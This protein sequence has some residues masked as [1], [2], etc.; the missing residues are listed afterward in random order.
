MEVTPEMQ[1]LIVR[2][3]HGLPLGARRRQFIAETVDCLR[4]SKR[5]AQHLFGWGRVT[6]RKA[7]QERQRGITCVDAFACRGRQAAEV[8]L[9]RLLEDIRAV[10]QDFVQTDPTF[11]TTR[12]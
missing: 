10:V 3:A 11:Q 4:L 1:Q 8:H 2:P 9:P 5:R 12:Q 7:L 6:I